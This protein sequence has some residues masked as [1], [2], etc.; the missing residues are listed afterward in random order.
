MKNTIAL[1]A[2]L[3]L[4]GAAHAQVFTLT[5][6]NSTAVFADLTGFGGGA[7]QNGWEVDGIS[8]LFTQDFIF[9]FRDGNGSQF[10]DNFAGAASLF[11]TNSDPG[12]DTL[13]VEY[14]NV[15]GL[16]VETT[17]ILRGGSANSGRAD[18]AEIIRLVNNSGSTMSFSFFQRVDLDLNGDTFDA[19]ATIVNANAV[20]QVDGIFGASETVNT[21]APTIGMVGSPSAVSDAIFIFE[22]LDGTAFASNGDL[23]W[24]W[25]WDITLNPGDTFLISKDK[26]ITPAPGTLALLGFGGLAASRRRRG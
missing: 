14:A 11:N 25:Q 3:A 2:I 12:L 6:A 20:Q 15:N 19:S 5:D 21:P 8:Q 7:Y 13:N 17:F 22:Q 1:G 18:L 24:A 10:L 9:N 16:A 23:G 26:S 4:A